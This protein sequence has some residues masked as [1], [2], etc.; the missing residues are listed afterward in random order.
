MSSTDNDWA[1]TGVQLEIG[2]KAT[3]FEHE[4][5]DVTY[6]KCLRYYQRAATTSANYLYLGTLQSYASGSVF[7]L[8]APY[9]APMRIKPAVDQSGTFQFS[10]TGSGNTGDTTIGN[11]QG[12]EFG[13]MSAGWGG[14]TTT[15]GYASSVRATH[16][17]YLEADAEL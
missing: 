1:I 17:A 2:E 10:L 15:A 6:R 11:L 9:L 4:S 13:W 7:G 14:G 5:Y 12:G 16:S 3:E 8:I